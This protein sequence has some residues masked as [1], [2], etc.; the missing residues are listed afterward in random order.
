MNRFADD[1]GSAIAEFVMVAGLLTLLALSVMQLAIA[2]HVRNTM[3]DSAAEGARYGALADS[4]LAQ[5]EA[6]T[7]DLITTAIGP[8]YAKS[9]RATIGTYRGYPAMTVTVTAPLP[10]F[11]LVGVDGL[12]EVA[13]HAAVEVVQR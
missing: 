12:V 9:V 1:S 5:A 2:L 3:T 7:A 6:R 11:G 4:S 10:V 8:D 13:G